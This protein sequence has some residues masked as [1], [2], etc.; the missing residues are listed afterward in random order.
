MLRLGLPAPHS[1]GRGGRA[2]GRAAA[3]HLGRPKGRE[4]K[5][6]LRPAADRLAELLGE[7]VVLAPSLDDVPDGDPQVLLSGFGID[8]SHSLANSLQWGPDGWL[9]GAAGST[10]TC[11]IPNPANPKEVVEFQQGLWDAIEH[12]Q[13]APADGQEP[14]RRRWASASAPDRLSRH[15]VGRPL[16][17]PYL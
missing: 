17:V 14:E 10:S 12:M 3:A 15:P 13:R 2:A 7:D 8:D 9:Y 6:S 1:P 11:K 5:F 4:E 16:R